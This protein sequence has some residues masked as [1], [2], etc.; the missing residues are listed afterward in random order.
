M[1]DVVPL[2]TVVDSGDVAGE[3]VVMGLLVTPTGLDVEG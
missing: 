1:E 3:A 2:D